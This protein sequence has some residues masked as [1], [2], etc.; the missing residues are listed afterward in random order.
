MAPEPG[1]AIRKKLQ[2]T[3]D[4]GTH[5][6]QRLMEAWREVVPKNAEETLGINLAVGRLVAGMVDLE[7]ALSDVPETALMVRLDRADETIGLMVVDQ[8]AVAAIL[9]VQT[10]GHVRRAEIP[11]R[12]PTPTDA[13]IVA[14]IIAPWMVA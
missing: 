1:Q 4:R 13:M 8:T 3:R 2:S 9:E 5:V 11:D 12:K 6:A 14:D 10:S 7:A